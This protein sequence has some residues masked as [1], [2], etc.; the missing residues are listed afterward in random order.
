MKNENIKFVV[1]NIIGDAVDGYSRVTVSNENFN[2]LRGVRPV[3]A[4]TAQGDLG[5]KGIRIFTDM[6]GVELYSNYDKE[7]R[8]T[9]FLMKTE[10][11]QKCLLTIADQRAKEPKLPF[12]STVFNRLV[13]ATA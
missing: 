11:A 5:G 3:L 10:D 13:V 8:K 12:N 2:D 1:R 7:S 9:L 4:Y 6:N